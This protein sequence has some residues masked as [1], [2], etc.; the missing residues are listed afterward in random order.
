MIQPTA[1][2]ITE[3]CKQVLNHQITRESA[4]Q[5]AFWFIENED[6]VEISDIKAWHYLVAVSGIDE[7]TAPNEYLYSVE[8]I[9]EWM[10]HEMRSNTVTAS[11][12]S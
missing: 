7:M 9:K 11:R 5:W 4:A 3:K 1:E 2:E 10:F 6:A 12:G 8:D